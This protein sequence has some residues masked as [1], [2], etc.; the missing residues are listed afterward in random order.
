MNDLRTAAQ[1]ALEA[2]HEIGWSNDTRW[3]SD[4]A[5]TVIPALKAALAEPVPTQSK[6]AAAGFTP[7][8]KRLECD[9]CGKKFTRLLL[10]IHK[11]S[12]ALLGKLADHVAALA[13]PV[14]EPGNGGRTGWP[15][16]LLQDDCRGLSKWLASR[17]DARQRLREALAEPETCTWQQDGDS[18]SGL[19]AT[20][21]RHYFN[22]E[23][24]TPEDNKMA[25]CCYCGKKLAQELITEN[26][27]E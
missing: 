18:D 22:L 6:L 1:Q 5:A 11:C 10:P 12:G 17:P 4:R 23:E 8:D 14:Q 24:G 21:C 27:D 19:Y 20:S 15:P 3:Q 2:L 9:E 7:R 25:W 16:G 13:E 26:E